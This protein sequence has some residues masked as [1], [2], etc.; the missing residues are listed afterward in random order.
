MTPHDVPRYVR[1][2]R[3]FTFALATLHVLLWLYVMYRTAQSGQ[4]GNTAIGAIFLLSVICL[5]SLCDH[6]LG[7]QVWWMPLLRRS[8]ELE[9]RLMA[10]ER[11]VE[12]LQ[13]SEA[14]DLAAEGQP[15]AS[16]LVAATLSAHSFPRLAGNA[17]RAPAQDDP[18]Q[19]WRDALAAGGLDDARQMLEG[20]RERKSV[21]FVARREAELA[22]AARSTFEQLRAR[23]VSQLRE[24][25]FYAALA[26]G[27]RISSLFPRS[28]PARDFERIRPLLQRRIGA[29]GQSEEAL[30]DALPG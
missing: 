10:L 15:R 17:V 18:P 12:A 25:D 28:R 9:D 22:A 1:H 21:D 27:R 30:I 20:W 7:A 3:R 24:G 13:A 2:A 29:G 8:A 11:R 19:S 23:F 26:T 6:L 5:W 16:E 4:I 14:I